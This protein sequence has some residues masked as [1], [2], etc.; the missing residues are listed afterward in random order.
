MGRLEG[1]RD[2]YNVAREVGTNRTGRE[3]SAKS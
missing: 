2:I 3:V 1:I